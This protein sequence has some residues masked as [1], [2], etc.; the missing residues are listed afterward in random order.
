MAALVSPTASEGC[1]GNQSFHQYWADSI[2][3]KIRWKHNSTKPTS[4][5]HS[6]APCAGT[7]NGSSENIALS[8]HKLMAHVGFWSQTSSSLLPLKAPPL[9]CVS[10]ARDDAGL[11][12]DV[13]PLSPV[14]QADGQNV[15]IEGEAVSF[16]APHPDQ[17]Y[18]III[19]ASPVVPVEDNPLHGQL[20][21]KLILHSRVVIA[22]P[23]EV[24]PHIN[25]KPGEKHTQDLHT[26]T[27][28]EADSHKSQLL[29]DWTTSSHYSDKTVS[30]AGLWDLFSRCNRASCCRFG[31]PNDY[32]PCTGFFFLSKWL[33]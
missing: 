12:V 15:V 32:L 1:Y 10:P 20:P 6:L 9:T 27:K 28:R 23:Q 5:P 24:A 17:G 19:A 3:L 2:N 4:C 14:R 26:P 25:T 22:H 13:R 7:D 11:P 29:W 31:V 30:P 33:P 18:V 21:L 8:W 16:S